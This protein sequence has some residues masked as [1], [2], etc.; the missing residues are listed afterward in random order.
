MISEARS[1]VGCV[2]TLAYLNEILCYLKLKKASILYED[3]FPLFEELLQLASVS[4]PTPASVRLR[5]FYCLEILYGLWMPVV[6]ADIPSLASGNCY[7][8]LLR[9]FSRTHEGLEQVSS[10]LRELQRHLVVTT[11]EYSMIGAKV[12]STR[13]DASSM[14]RS[15][16]ELLIVMVKVVEKVVKII[17]AQLSVDIPNLAEV[18]RILGESVYF[19][20]STTQHLQFAK[21]LLNISEETG[22]P[23]WKQRQQE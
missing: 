14:R 3:M 5:A 22:I 20:F 17:K 11:T 12:K 13:P 10:T 8:L 9:G 18:G 1:G 7:T 16:M 6:M 21:N 2:L 4:S 23:T 19:D 15:K